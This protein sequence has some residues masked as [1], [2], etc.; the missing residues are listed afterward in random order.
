MSKASK[1]KIYRVTHD[2]SA[3]LPE[4]AFILSM[5]HDLGYAEIVVQMPASQA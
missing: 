2:K 4:G 1:I 5:K 3:D